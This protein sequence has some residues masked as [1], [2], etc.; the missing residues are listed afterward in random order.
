MAD[1]MPQIVC[2]GRKYGS[3]G[4][5][6]GEHLAERLGVPCYDKLLIKKTAAESGLS[7]DFIR[8]EEET[9][10]QS[11]WFLSGNAFADSAALSEAFYSGS[12]MIYDAEQKVIRQLA[13]KGP[14]VIVGRCASEL[15]KGS[16]VLRYELADGTTILVR[17]SGTEPKIKVYILTKGADAADRDANIEKYSAWVK[18]LT[19]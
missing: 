12:Q 10:A 8:Q 6:I 4:R 15:L 18:T 11:R 2:V 1:K 17:P 3:G 5:E 14:C 13:E 7:E 19:E 9:P 16:N